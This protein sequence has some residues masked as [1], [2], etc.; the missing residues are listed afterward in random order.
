MGMRGAIMILPIKFMKKIAA[1]NRSG[2]SWD[3]NEGSSEWLESR[4]PL[5]INDHLTFKARI[6]IL[7]V[8]LFILSTWDRIRMI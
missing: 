7:L 2:P 5:E 8:W 1:K 3:R 6:F 4:L